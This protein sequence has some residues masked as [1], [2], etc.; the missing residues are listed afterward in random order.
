[1]FADDKEHLI[2]KA[3]SRLWKCFQK[4]PISCIERQGVKI[5]VTWVKT[6]SAL[7][8]KEAEEKMAKADKEK[9]DKAGGFNREKDAKLTPQKTVSVV[10]VSWSRGCVANHSPPI[11]SSGT[12]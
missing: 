10:A 9:A 12:S 2:V 7:Q 3:N 4:K 5:P 1:M 8:G 6:S 11:C